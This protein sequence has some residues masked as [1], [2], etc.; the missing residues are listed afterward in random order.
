M[1]DIYNAIILNCYGDTP[2]ATGAVAA[3]CGDGTIN[4]PG[5]ISRV[6]RKMME[7]RDWEFMRRQAVVAI[8]AG[9]C[10]LNI[11]DSVKNI[12]RV[13]YQQPDLY[14]SKPLSFISLDE[15]RYT[16]PID[17]TAPIYVDGTYPEYFAMRGNPTIGYE[18]V[19]LELYPVPGIA[20]NIL[21]EYFS[22]GTYGGRVQWV[23]LDGVPTTTPY[24]EGMVLLREPVIYYST[25]EL[26]K[27]LGEFNKSQV[28]EQMGAT[29]YANC[30][31]MDS[32]MKAPGTL[33][34]RYKGV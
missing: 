20:M 22:F 12:I 11:A 25:A 13:R 4:N 15:A 3:L 16:F 27:I 9:Q 30:M 7:D 31:Y 26:C 6:F 24:P 29:A 32:K 34:C 33:Q 23:F 10:V 17:P 5:I 2:P 8:T 21:K 14:Y 19:S 28:F 18:E 1:L